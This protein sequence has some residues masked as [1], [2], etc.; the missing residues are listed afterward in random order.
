[1]L[2]YVLPVAAS[3]IALLQ[4]AKD[5]GA[6]QTT[7]RRGAALVLIVLFGVGSAINSYYASKGATVQHQSDQR[8]IAGLKI[9]V[10]S[11]SRSGIKLDAFS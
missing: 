2:N 8:E 9:A 7:W 1:M 6:H 5:W 11:E 10:D 3:L 4:L